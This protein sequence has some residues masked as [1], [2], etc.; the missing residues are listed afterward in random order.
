MHI[1]EV[2]CTLSIFRI[3]SAIII[4]T[5]LTAVFCVLYFC[6][7]ALLYFCTFVLFV[8]V[9][10]ANSG[11]PADGSSSNSTPQPQLASRLP[12]PQPATVLC[13]M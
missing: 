4:Y 9:K 6:T 13:N 11:R 2:I 10:M 8:D 12:P 3:T 1:T 7:F 5:K